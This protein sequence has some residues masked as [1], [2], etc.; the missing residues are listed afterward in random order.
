MVKNQID[1]KEIPGWPGYKV[2][3]DAVVYGRYGEI[4][5]IDTVTAEN[6][7]KTR[8]GLPVD[9]RHRVR[10]GGRGKQK[11]VLVA[12][13]VCLAFHG[14][15]PENTGLHYL[16]GN[17]ENDHAENLCWRS[18][19]YITGRPVPG[20]NG[21]SVLLKNDGSVKIVGRQG[22]LKMYEL[23]DEDLYD[24][25]VKIGGRFASVAALVC[26]T[27]NG[28]PKDSQVVVHIDGNTNNLKPENLK[29]G[30]SKEAKLA[31]Y[32]HE[33]GYNSLTIQ[34]RIKIWDMGH[35]TG[36]Q[37]KYHPHDLAL[38]FE[39]NDDVILGIVFGDR[40][41]MSPSKEV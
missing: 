22:E 6:I 15:Q 41:Q 18:L 23:G 38:E 2:T 4:E 32:K 20:R 13:L 5:P 1:A 36:G 17:D 39:C 9:Y 34:D 31:L 29:W 19:D 11:N 3:A 35:G 12:E 28:E 27:F 24:W 30:A 8:R 16:D 21:Y 40:P 25:R 10:I 14:P 7:E 26:R 33:S 37:K